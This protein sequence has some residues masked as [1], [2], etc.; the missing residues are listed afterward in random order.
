MDIREI[1]AT[2]R[3]A[4][5]VISDLKYKTIVV[6]PWAEL[7]KEY[8]P[9]KHP[10]KTDKSYK[11]KV[12]KGGIE[13]VTRI[14]LGWQKLA[15]KRISELMYAI[16]VLRKY[17]PE[18]EQEQKVAKIMEAIF[19]KNRI[20]SLNIDRAKLLFASCEMVTLWYSQE[21]EAI[22]AGE[23]S[24]LKLRCKTFSPKDG[25]MI[26]PLFDEYDD[27]IALSIEYTR[28]EGKEHA[29]YFDTYTAEEH[30]RW[31]TAGGKTEEELRE[32]IEL[33]KITG[34]YIHR[35]EPIWE[36]QS[37][38]VYEAEWT[39]SRNG[40][41]IRKNARPNWVVFSDKKVQHGKEDKSDNSAR[42]V[43][44]YGKDDKAGYVTWAQATDSIKYHIDEIR[45]EFFM[46]LQLPDMSMEN[47]KATPMSGEA[48][49]MMF[50]D[51]QLKVVDESGAWLDFFHRE[52]NVVRAFMKKMY[53]SLAAAIESLQVEVFITPYQI[54]D[55]SE[56]IANLSDAT[57]GK[58]IMSQ[59]TAIQN[60]GSVED[61]DEELAQ[62][63][64]E[65]TSNL[66]EEPTF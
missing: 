17:K 24:P 65:G 43:L 30:I 27:L 51:A 3:D 54:R 50:I 59:R 63:Q 66:L 16:P 19:N 33:G 56:R 36:D 18:N 34:V 11:D 48:R 53:P 1:T 38:N 60:L 28:N 31:R 4:K 21:A 35:D 64:K 32:T 20:D 46:Q 61:A 2:E 52:I 62:I 10:V 37:D 29:T 42:N 58:P 45:R 23:K 5:S 25:S 49:K 7:E 26:Y 47:M 57:G 39:R 8:N 14:T 22:Y 9:K 13:K 15:V 44:Q 55:E 12:T 40:N 41:Y 6:R